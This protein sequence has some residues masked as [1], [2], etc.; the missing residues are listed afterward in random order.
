MRHKKNRGK[1]GAVTSR[2]DVR[3]FFGGS[4]EARTDKQPALTKGDTWRKVGNRHQYVTL[5]ARLL[6]KRK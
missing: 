4:D 1:K 3:P 5:L 6:G 2:L